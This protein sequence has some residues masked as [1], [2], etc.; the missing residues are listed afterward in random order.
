V[1]LWVFAENSYED[2][3]V[4]IRKSFLSH[5]NQPHGIAQPL[6]NRRPLDLYL[7]VIQDIFFVLGN[8]VLINLSWLLVILT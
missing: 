7:R 1:L 6:I 5:K 2:L 3:L 4:N 8:E